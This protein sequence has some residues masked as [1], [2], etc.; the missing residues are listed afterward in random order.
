MLIAIIIAVIILIPLIAAAVM[1][2]DYVI[3]ADLNINKPLREVFDFVKSLR[4]GEKFN[5]WVMAD[6]NLRK[7]FIGTDG[8]VGFVYKWDSDMKNVGQ[9]EQEITGITEGQ[10]I[11]YEIR[12]IKPFANIAGSTIVTQPAGDGTTNVSW[13][14]FGKRTFGMRIF[15]FLFNLKKVLKKDLHTSL[16]NLK[17]ILEK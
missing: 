6:P 14:F 16:V 7:E 9:G 10:S 13:S 12:F 17:N 5:K 3:V 8:T 1:S 11:T 15:H 4:N 2:E